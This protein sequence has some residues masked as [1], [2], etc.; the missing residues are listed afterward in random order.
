MELFIHTAGKED[1]DVVEVEETLLVR[2]LITG[3]DD[4]RI[5]M[6]E[7][8]EEVTLDMTLADAGIHHHHHVHRGRCARVEVVVRHNGENF[9]HTF[10]PG[11]TIK[12]VEKW[13]FGDK[14]AD[15]SPDQAAKHVLALPGADHFLAATVHVGSLV[16]VGGCQVTLDLLPRDRFEG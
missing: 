2:E 10:G 9:T 8:D 4:G 11:T 13:A 12:T 7:V 1:P 16:A 14:A 15:L 5:W 6:E 3:E